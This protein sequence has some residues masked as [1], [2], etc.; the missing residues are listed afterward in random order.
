MTH[1]QRLPR[2]GLLAALVAIGSA[3]A[4]TEATM[5]DRCAREIVELHGFFE[6][7]FNDELDDA[8]FTRLEQALA[9]DFVMVTPDGRV[10]E[11]RTLLEGLRGARGAWTGGRDRPGGR[12]RVENVRAQW[13]G[14]GV[15][16]LTY[17]EWQD[18]D[19]VARGRLSSVV[20]R[21]RDDAPNGVEWVH[22]HETWLPDD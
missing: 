13:I 2:I 15:A 10:V 21:P 4:T 22:L 8:A 9:T 1:L 17:E 11:R 7:W 5:E 6:G 16:V 14:S 12:I 19:G 3:A 20:M 18:R